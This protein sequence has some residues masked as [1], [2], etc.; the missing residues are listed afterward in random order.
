M[1][2][3]IFE[4]FAAKPDLIIKSNLEAIILTDSQNPSGVADLA[5]LHQEMNT[6]DGWVHRDGILF[7]LHSF[8]DRSVRR[9]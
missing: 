7:P 9:Q 6:A 4:L 2:D 1:W 3:L 8:L 5:Y